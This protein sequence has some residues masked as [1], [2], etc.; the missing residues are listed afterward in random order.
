M[1]TKIKI[2]LASDLDKTYQK[3]E[4]VLSTT[5]GYR[6]TLTNIRSANRL[7]S[8]LKNS[9]PD[10]L[11]ICDRSQ[12]G[13]SLHQLKEAKKQT[14]GLPVLILLSSFDSSVA[15][16]FIENGADDV[17]SEKNLQRLPLAMDLIF[18]KRGTKPD[19]PVD[20]LDHAVH[21][22][23]TPLHSISLLGD[24][25]SLNRQGNLDRDQIKKAEVIHE[26][27]EHLL[28]LLENL[29][30]DRSPECVKP[31]QEIE[32]IHLEHFLRM[33]ETLFLPAARKKDLELSF[34]RHENLE[35]TLY[36]Y[37]TPLFQILSNLLGNALKFTPSGKIEVHTFHPDSDELKASRL[38]ATEQDI[39]ELSNHQFIAFR[40][41]DTGIGISADKLNRIFQPYRQADFTT[42]VQY[43]GSGLG[44]AISHDLAGQLGG[45][46]K[47]KSQEGKGS[48]FTLYLPVKPENGTAK[49]ATRDSSREE[50]SRSDD[51]FPQLES[52]LIVDDSELHCQA[53]KEYLKDIA[54]KIYQ[55]D[56]ANRARELIENTSVDIVILDL[57]LPDEGGEGLLKS[58]KRNP[59]TR[60]IPVII[61]TGQ[62]LTQYQVLQLGNLAEDVIYKSSGSYR[63]LKKCIVR[64]RQ[65][66]RI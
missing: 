2:I 24:L 54:P 52:L 23:R 28:D 42:S 40:V 38:E 49:A 66:Q 22:L 34:H 3:V 64:I 9:T 5:S 17:I 32:E 21:E 60:H 57:T 7:A 11:I 12:K 53:L 58:I 35:K 44:L 51:T 16:K 50:I 56:T 47:V 39:D 4:E 33:M 13:N 46:I 65:N 8:S 18:N 15:R 59:A 30:S 14:Y 20:L 6:F 63:K 26:T 29:R 36:T 62:N 45:D 25:L 19:L 48:S 55:A 37:R 43:G 27:S 31:D 1:G 61:Y 41:I 10:L